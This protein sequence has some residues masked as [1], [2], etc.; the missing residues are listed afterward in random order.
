MNFAVYDLVAGIR[1]YS[2]M[3]ASEPAEL[4]PDYAKWMI[5]D[6]RV[7]FT[8]FAPDVLPCVINLSGLCPDN[9]SAADHELAKRT[10]A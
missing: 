5:D 2:A 1:F 3:F 9:V 7:S 10:S 6:P 8:I 4:K